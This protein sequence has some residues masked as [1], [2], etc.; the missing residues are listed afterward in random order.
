MRPDLLLLAKSFLTFNPFYLVSR[1]PSD[2]Y[3]D[4]GGART[5]GLPMDRVDEENGILNATMDSEDLI[6]SPAEHTDSIKRRKD[7][8]RRER[9]DKTPRTKN[10]KSH[11]AVESRQGTPPTARPPKARE[12]VDDTEEE[13]IWLA[14][15]WM[16]C[17]SFDGQNMMPKR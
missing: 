12:A 14:K 11:I 16:W 13:D 4:V 2:Q 10:T 1:Q 9:M 8:K 3:S 5:A 17:L 6:F 7:R 15:W